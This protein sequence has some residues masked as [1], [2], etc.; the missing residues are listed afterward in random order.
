VP[1]ASVVTQHAGSGLRRLKARGG[2][3][4]PDAPV[5]AGGSAHN[6][7]LRRLHATVPDPLAPAHS[8]SA[9]QGRGQGE[10]TMNTQP[11][12]VWVNG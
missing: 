10:R 7:A 6:P 8:G 12:C 4:A 5:P 11:L 3:S 2:A 1:A 9:Q